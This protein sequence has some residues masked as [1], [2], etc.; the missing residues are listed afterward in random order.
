[1]MCALHGCGD[2]GS[3]NFAIECL[4]ASKHITNDSG[5]FKGKASQ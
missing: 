5:Q 2:F 4:V 1:M 3:W